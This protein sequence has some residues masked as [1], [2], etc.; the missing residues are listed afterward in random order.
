MDLGGLV[1]QSLDPVLVPAGF[2][3]G[4]GGAGAGGDVQVI[5]CTA[6][7]DFSRRYPRLPQADRQR[8]GACVD[9]VVDARADG[10]LARLDLEDTSVEQTLLHCGLVAD[11]AAVSRAGGRP[12]AE[13]LPVLEAALRRLF[14]DPG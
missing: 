2:Q 7:D 13:S 4:Q 14:A 11:S 1:T 3:R 8:D 12:L 6:H 10:T 9:L 5:F